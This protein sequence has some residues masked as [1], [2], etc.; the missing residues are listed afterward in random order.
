LPG[1][2]RPDHYFIGEIQN[3]YQL[4]GHMEEFLKIAVPAFVGLISGAFH[5][6]MTN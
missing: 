1:D 3:I 4:L 5:A 2:G 6:A